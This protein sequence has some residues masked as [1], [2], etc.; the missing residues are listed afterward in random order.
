MQTKSGRFGC[1]RVWCAVTALINNFEHAFHASLKSLKSR[2]NFISVDGA[3]DSQFL[4]LV[5]V[6]WTLLSTFS[7]ISVILSSI[8][9]CFLSCFV[10]LLS[11]FNRYGHHDIRV[12]PF[13]VIK[14]V[15]L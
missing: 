6:V 4:V 10:F 7:T 12:F 8:A 1:F 5:L 15:S 14:V 13:K 3:S 2:L 9:F 11:L